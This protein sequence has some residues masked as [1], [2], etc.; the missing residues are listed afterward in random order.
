MLSF[1]CAFRAKPVFS[2]LCGRLD[3]GTCSVQNLSSEIAKAVVYDGEG[4]GI[5]P[6]VTAQILLR[7][8]DE[9]G[10]NGALLKALVAE[11]VISINSTKEQPKVAAA[12]LAR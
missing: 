1:F 6:I 8:R 9:I 12:S 5:A 3:N 7:A 4:S 10:S 11:L 2:N